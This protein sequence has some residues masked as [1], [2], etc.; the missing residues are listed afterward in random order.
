MMNQNGEKPDRKFPFFVL[1]LALVYY[2]QHLDVAFIQE[3]IHEI[4]LVVAAI[5][6]LYTFAPVKEFIRKRMVALKRKPQTI[7][8]LGLLVAFVYYSLNLTKVSN[9][10]AAFNE[11]GNGMGLCEFAMML[12]LVLVMVCFLNTFPHRKKVNIP[13]LVLMLAMMGVVIFCNFKYETGIDNAL[14]QRYDNAYD[15]HV[16]DN[17]ENIVEIYEYLEESN[18]LVAD[19]EAK[20]AAARAN[21]DS[22]ALLA[23]QV[24]QVADAVAAV[25]TTE[26]EESPAARALK[27]AE[28]AA[29]AAATAE[30]SA[31]S[32]AKM[33]GNMAK[34]IPAVQEAVDQV[35]AAESAKDISNANKAAKK[36][37]TN[38]VKNKGRNVDKYYNAAVTARTTAAEA[39]TLALAA[40][41]EVG[42]TVE[43]AEVPALVEVTENTET[44]AEIEIVL[45]QFIIDEAK[46]KGETAKEDAKDD[47]PDVMK[48]KN[49]MQVHRIIMYVALALI[50][51][52][53]V[54]KPLLRKVR[55]SIE[56]EATKEMGEIELDSSAE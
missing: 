55:T 3:W 42:V 41:E 10:T 32:V 30:E 20:A 37:A 24:K 2:L 9:T 14:Q 47:N 28:D 46:V 51:L 26:G 56:V 5:P 22:A 12:L 53:P 18:A 40:A 23:E 54:Y 49:V 16:K 33:P 17:S 35:A 7:A 13:M 48:A 8:L 31:T 11:A 44:A 34:G 36:A 25:D 15:K 21:A 6:F 50:V 1:A 29:A 45:P 27:A 19:A 4:T 39:L 43:L 52:L 38:E